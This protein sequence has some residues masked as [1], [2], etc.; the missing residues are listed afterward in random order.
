[1]EAKLRVRDLYAGDEAMIAWYERRIPGVTSVHDLNKAIHSNGGDAF[2]RLCLEDLLTGPLP[3]KAAQWPDFISIGR[4]LFPCTYRCDPA[5]ELDGLT[6]HLPRGASQFVSDE[7]LSWLV[8]PQ[9]AK[10]IEAMFERLPRETRKRLSPLS[11]SAERCAAMLR[12]GQGHFCAS[13]SQVMKKAFDL[14]CAAADLMHLE[15]PAYLRPHVA[16]DDER[17]QTKTALDRWQSAIATWERKSLERWD[18]GD[19]PESVIV[20]NDP[21]GFPLIRYPALRDGGT[22]VD[23]VAA[24]TEAEAKRLHGAGVAAFVRQELEQELSWLRK[25]ASVDAHDRLHLAPLGEVAQVFQKARGAVVEKFAAPDDPLCRS[26]RQFET[27][28]ARAKQELAPALRRL[29]D[30]MAKSGAL[31]A[32][33]AG[34]LAGLR[35]SSSEAR[36]APV[37]KSLIEE[38]HAVIATVLSDEA[39]WEYLSRLQRYLKRLDVAAQRAVDDPARYW[40]RMAAVRDFEERLRSAQGKPLAPRRHCRKLLEEYKISL[41]AQQEVKALPG[42]S[43]KKL[44][45][46]FEQLS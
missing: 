39:D 13:L 30:D 38:L 7:M 27:H 12:P 29:L 43:E 20:V 22:S 33:I 19:L 40:E 45:E 31:C 35:K 8:E 17:P 6:L 26:Q 9:W 11:E 4:E 15:I 5:S 25:N 32:G 2:L 1:L 36:K 16:F 44:R 21:A 46:A 3:Q 37:V 10:R 18:F 41:F 14:D 23:L 28:V 34:R 42:T 24:S